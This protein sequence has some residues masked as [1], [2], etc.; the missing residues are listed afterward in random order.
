MPLLD[1]PKSPSRILRRIGFGFL[2]LITLVLF[3]AVYVA[4]S[5]AT[6]L[7][8]PNEEALNADLL[9]SVREK[10]L[11]GGD[12]PG[13]VASVTV[14][15]EGQYPTNGTGEERPAKAT[16]EV[17]IYNNHNKSQTLIVTTRLLSKDGVLFRLQKTVTVAPGA[18]VK[19][20][21][22]ADKE[23]RS[24][25]VDPTSFTIPGLAANLQTK[26]YAK[27]A[28]PTVGGGFRIGIIMEKDIDA[29]IEDLKTILL[30]EAAAQLKEELNGDSQFSNVIFSSSIK[31]KEV[32]AKTGDKAANFKV[33]LELDV[34]GVAYGAALQDQAEKTISGMM[35][36]DRK[37]VSS[38]IA[39]LRPSIEKY[40]LEDKSANLKIGLTGNTIISSD[41]PVFDRERLAGM[42]G[43]E[44]K[45][46]LEKYAGIKNVEIK[47]FPFWLDRVPKLRNHVKVIVQ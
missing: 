25:E 27:S 3:V 19:A 38:N 4:L 7:V 31:A 11:R 21:I 36:S 8:S 17:T 46:Y 45:N 40:D 33:K 14:S 5:R 16:G 26:I 30:D 22:I 23:G 6:I 34:I 2:G 10:D 41:S 47:F 32:S 44:V 13:R 37:L 24:G 20:S 42:N 28:E 15:R 9:V 12:I 35:P 18:N 29:A 39:E 1:A 43:N